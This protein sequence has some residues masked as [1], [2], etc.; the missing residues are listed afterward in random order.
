MLARFTARARAR[1]LAWLDTPDESGEDGAELMV[2]YAANPQWAPRSATPARVA[3]IL[4]SMLNAMATHETLTGVFSQFW[5]T[6]MTVDGVTHTSTITEEGRGLLI[7]TTVLAFVVALFIVVRMF[8]LIRQ[9]AVAVSAAAAV[10]AAALLIL[11][12][13]LWRSHIED[14]LP[15]DATVIAAGT[16]LIAVIVAAVES[17]LC[18]LLLLFDRLILGSVDRLTASDRRFVIAVLLLSVMISIG[19]IIYRALEGWSYDRAISFVLSTITTIGYGNVVPATVGGQVFTYFYGVAGIVAVGFTLDAS[20][21]KI[22]E[23]IVAA[24][25]RIERRRRFFRRRMA[26]VNALSVTERAATSLRFNWI[27]A[28]LLVLLLWLGG[29]GVFVALEHDWTYSAGV[30]FTFSTLTT[31]GYGDYYPTTASAETFLNYF[32]FCG[33]AVIAYMLSL[34]GDT[35]RQSLESKFAKAEVRSTN[36]GRG[37]GG[38]AGGL[39]KAGVCGRAGGWM[40]VCGRAG[41]WVWEGGRGWAWEGGRVRAGGWV[42]G[43]VGDLGSFLGDCVLRSR[44]MRV[45]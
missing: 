25:K 3:V 33:L 1:V 35:T 27:V 28:F 4:A 29:A 7:A 14:T 24:S 31:I 5:C 38:R 20:R 26:M 13:A 9:I 15:A 34:V 21:D 42:D 10:L 39:G 45:R 11:T 30:W 36:D 2:L 43:R 32:V 12:S 17:L 18:A 23:M 19:A 40:G 41:G 44:F 6:Y 16:S 22:V 37:V 8:G